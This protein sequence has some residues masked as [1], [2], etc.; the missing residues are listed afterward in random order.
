MEK[1]AASNMFAKASLQGCESLGI[2]EGRRTESKSVAWRRTH[3]DF[4]ELCQI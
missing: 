1:T 4:R 3:V 2:L